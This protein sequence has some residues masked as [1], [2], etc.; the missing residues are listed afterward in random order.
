MEIT[1]EV[2]EKFKEIKVAVNYIPECFKLKKLKRDIK[3]IEFTT[4]TQYYNFLNEEKTFWEQYR[5]NNFLNRYY[6]AYS[7]AIESFKNAIQ[8][9]NNNQ[10]N[11][12]ISEGINRIYEIPN[13]K[14]ILV[15]EMV[16]FHNYSDK[17]YSG[18]IEGL[19]DG[20]TQISSYDYSKYYL[21]GMM[22]AF[23]YKEVIRKIDDLLPDEQ[24]SIA[25]AQVSFM[26]TADEYIS[27]YN[28]LYQAQQTKFQELD[29]AVKTGLAE[30][31]E[32]FKAFH[33][34][35]IKKMEDLEKLYT[36]NLRLKKPADYWLTMSKSYNKKAKWSMGIAIG[37]AI[38]TAVIIAI[39]IVNMPELTS[40]SHWYDLLKNTALITVVTSILIYIIRILVKI[41][42]SSFHLSSD[43]KEREQL[44]YFYLSLIN[45]KAVTD[46]ER[47]LVITS[48]F[49]R[50]DTGL[51]KGDS[52]PEMPSINVSDFFNKK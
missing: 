48:L 32:K 10:F 33:D 49:S 19:K 47:E 35:K 52:S 14:S 4:A 40:D 28:E 36:E 37:L 15:R 44:T 2:E 46:K 6:I 51:L 7:S 24:G 8:N 11:M 25:D 29:L 17:F 50:S 9:V 3:K 26:A 18:Y 1:K 43:A 38:L 5:T 42:M 16:K 27:K 23:E 31:S 13:S 45:E 20:E 22:K 39:M 41:G 30:E 21:L 12:Y 34:E